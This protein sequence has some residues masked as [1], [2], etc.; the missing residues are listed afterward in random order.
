SEGATQLRCFVVGELPEVLEDER[1]TLQG[2]P[3]KVALPVTVNGRIY[4]RGDLD[5]YEFTAKAGDLLNCEVLSQRL[6]HKLDARLELF[7]AG[8]R[9]LAANADG[10]GRDPILIATLP[11]DG[12]YVLRIHDIAFEGNQDYVYRLTVRTGPAV[13]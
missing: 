1:E 8:G 6:G 10:A 11:G 2:H 5:E 13:T 4:P 7:D 9:S 3:Q 12:R